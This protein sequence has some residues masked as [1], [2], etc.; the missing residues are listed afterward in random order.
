MARVSSNNCPNCGAALK[1]DS[2]LQ[3]VHSVSCQ[4][5]G[6]VV[7]VVPAAA[8]RR[9]EL[10][11]LPK[12]P[13]GPHVVMLDEKQVSPRAFGC[14]MAFVVFGIMGFILVGTV[15][16]K[17]FPYLNSRFNPWLFPMNCS[18]GEQIVI[19]GR[20]ETSNEPLINASTFCKIRIIDSHLTAPLLVKGDTGVEIIAENSEL[21]VARA[22]LDGK[23]N[24]KL[25]L[26]KGSKVHTNE[27]VVI[28]DTWASV[29]LSASSI[30]SKGG[31]VKG[32]N[33]PKLRARDKS[34][35]VAVKA[36][37]VGPDAE[38]LL[39]DSEMLLATS[40]FEEG[41]DH[42]KLS[43]NNRSTIRSE[44]IAVMGGSH[45]EIS[46]SASTITG[47]NG[48]I[49]MKDHDKLTLSDAATIRSPRDAVQFQNHATV[50]VGSGST[51]EAGTSALRVGKDANI[52]ISGTVG[53]NTSAISAEDY[54]K[55]VLR[56]ATVRGPI[57]VTGSYS[58]VKQE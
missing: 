21:R 43:V 55:V 12:I 7:T 15:G 3:T 42:V 33:G 5:C 47:K 23:T 37:M 28:G 8:R 40:V 9:T 53:G 35:V 58:S 38:V 10:G 36:V 6:T 11:E 51:I 14:V 27:Y 25:E 30:E 31:V 48:A 46:V 24:A 17:F 16:S 1:L 44:N 52:R 20:T 22:V 4:Y 41:A 39:D 56:R 18:T 34:R 32:E 54:S 29:S 13:S 49:D 19:W 26:R 57:S 45:S 50:D 2:R